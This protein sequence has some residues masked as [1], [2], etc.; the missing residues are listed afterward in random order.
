[1]ALVELLTAIVLGIIFYE[2]LRYRGVKWYYF[3]AL[4][5]LMV[6]RFV[7]SEAN[8][9]FIV[10]NVS[11]VM[12]QLTVVALYFFLRYGNV[13]IFDRYIGWGDLLLWA[14]L[15]FA[16][17]PLNFVLF[18]ILS[19]LFSLLCYYLFIRGENK[20]I[21]LAGFQS[22]FLLLIFGARFFGFAWD[23]YSDYQLIEL[24]Y[25]S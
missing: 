4:L 14:V 12:S 20:S 18:F 1:M 23:N 5:S 10:V 15:I 8:L 7:E 9:V 3:P 11:F 21:P 16:F 19:A 25:G 13:K 6:W 24:L 17:S 22:L 2:D